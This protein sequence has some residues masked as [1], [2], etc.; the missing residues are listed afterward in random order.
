MNPTLVHIRFLDAG[1]LERARAAVREVGGR[2]IEEFDGILTAEVPAKAAAHLSAAFACSFPAGDAERTAPEMLPDER[3]LFP[4]EQDESLATARNVLTTFARRSLNVGLT[5][6]GA[7]FQLL[8]SARTAA[9]PLL[10][11]LDI[12]GLWGGVKRFLPTVDELLAEDAYLIRLIGAVRPAWREELLR[13]GE[14]GDHHPPDVFRMVLTREHLGQVQAL[15]YVRRV[16]RYGLLETLS[17]ALLQV[18]HTVNPAHTGQFDLTVHRAADLGRVV[19]LV[20]HLPGVRIVSQGGASLRLETAIGSDVLAALAQLPLIRTL[21]PYVAPRLFLDQARQVIGVVQINAAP[22]AGLGERWTGRGQVVALFDSG[23]DWSHPDLADALAAP[24]SAAGAGQPLDRTGHGTHVAGIIAGRGI[25]SGGALRG[26]APESRLFSVGVVDSAGRLDVPTDLGS[27]LQRAVAVGANIINLSWGFKLHTDYDVYGQSIDRFLRDN[28]E[29]LVV[30][31]AG[32]EGQAPEGL[33]LPGTI[34]MPAGAKNVL[35]VGACGGNR[36]EYPRTWGETPGVTFPQP[37]AS[38]ERVAGVPDFPAAVSS[39]GPTAFNAIKPDLLAPGTVVLSARS[40]ISTV[41]YV[42]YISPFSAYGYLNG[43]SMAAPVVAG[44]AALVRQYLLEVRALP[45][46]SS[47]LLR[48][49]L[50][51]S[52]VRLPNANR[53]SKLSSTACPTLGFPDF[54]Q[55]FGRLDLRTLL[56]HS[57]A[58]TDRRLAFA[59]VLNDSPEALQALQPPNGPRRSMRTYR[60]T[61]PA[62]SATP[63]RVVLAWTDVPGRF[64]QNGLSLRVTP[65]DFRFVYGNSEH[66]LYFDPVSLA[67]GNQPIDRFNNVLAVCF[68]NPLPGEYRLTV[69]AEST[70]VPYQ[71]YALAVS[72]PL[73]DDALTTLT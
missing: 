64:V 16:K 44:A 72:G 23:I 48:A 53:N 38:L 31:A 25:A 13:F 58:P 30:A 36:A 59:D 14:L 66:R 50:I 62:A 34:G 39:R 29:V 63:I 10:D 6:D 67:L 55:G 22:P 52:A 69:L 71:G 27:L 40:N 26:I 60:V 70:P 5:S 28:P 7:H 61:V 12:E 73:A 3:R 9:L 49:L 17:P 33:H 24:P 32:N 20:Q 4:Q 41:G 21:S 11:G 45:R 57:A 51:L 46:P 15:P 68:P 2:V 54:D 43:T 37:P 56:P 18:L 35:A 47:A 1:E 19:S 42:D 65:P 8:G